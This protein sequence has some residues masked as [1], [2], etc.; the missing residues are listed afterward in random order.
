M[1]GIIFQLVGKTFGVGAYIHDGDKV[2]L[3][4]N[5][6]LFRRCGQ[7][8]PPNPSKPVNRNFCSHIR[9]GLSKTP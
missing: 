4:S 2:Q 5:K 7:N 6:S 3:F 9:T 1:D 8:E